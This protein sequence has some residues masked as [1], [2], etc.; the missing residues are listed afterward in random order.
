M[1]FSEK[2]IYLP[3]E[4][5]LLP[6]E[7]DQGNESS[8]HARGSVPRVICHDEGNVIYNQSTSDLQSL[9]GLHQV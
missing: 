5:C 4:L 8:G 3:N 1:G 9:V 2:K 7:S 6:V